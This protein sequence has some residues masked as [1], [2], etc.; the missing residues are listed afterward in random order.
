MTAEALGSLPPG[1]RGHKRA[2]SAA[3][4]DHPK[5]ST[6]IVVCDGRECKFCGCVDTS[7]DPVDKVLLN[8]RVDNHCMTMAWFTDR[9][10]HGEKNEGMVCFY[11]YSVFQARYKHRQMAMKQVC[12]WNKLSHHYIFQWVS[13]AN[14]LRL[15]PALFFQLG[16]LSRTL[17]LCTV[18][19]LRPSLWT[20]IFRV[21]LWRAPVF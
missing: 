19:G 20:M 11:C 10:K 12:F 5:V 2:L 16:I 1:P 18:V 15:L 17:V 21:I 3:G 4:F 9:P 8:M 13:W 14:G 7:E 6:T